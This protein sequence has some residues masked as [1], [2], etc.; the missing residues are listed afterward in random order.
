MKNSN[1]QRPLW[2]KDII[3]E[4]STKSRDYDL[5]FSDNIAWDIVPLIQWGTKFNPKDGYEDIEFPYRYRQ[6]R[7]GSVKVIGS[8]DSFY[9]CSFDKATY[10]YASARDFDKI[11]GNIEVTPL[12][13]FKDLLNKDAVFFMPPKICVR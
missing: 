8:E 13:S 1:E 10:I 9:N 12:K 7:I 6:S 3:T 11:Q 4:V 2:L 5:A